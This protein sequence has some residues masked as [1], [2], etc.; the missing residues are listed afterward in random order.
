MKCAV[1]DQASPKFFMNKNGYDLY[2][3]S[4]CGLIFVWPLPKDFAEIYS[5]DYFS[6]A[7]QGFGYADYNADKKPMLS[8]WL[9]YLALI[10]KLLPNKGRLLD[11]GAATG[12]FMCLAKERGWQVNGVEISDFAARSGRK[13]GLEI[14]TGTLE[15]APFAEESFDLITM[16]DVVEHLPQPR[17]FFSRASRLLKKGGVIVINTPDA[18]SILAGLLGKRWHLIVPPEHL[19]YFNLNSLSL[20]LSKTGFKILQHGKIGKKFTLHYVVK[21]IENRF[22]RR[23]FFSSQ[24]AKNKFLKKIAIPINTRDNFFV[25]AKKV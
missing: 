4:G 16:W 17:E 1:C 13:A 19:H 25:L 23:G 9:K 20:L 18:G 5:Q 3:C 14:F 2:R 10:E 21:F 7:S 22:S 6:G 24:I 11:V 15:N 8:A 12:F